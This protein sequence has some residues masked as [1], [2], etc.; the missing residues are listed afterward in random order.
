MKHDRF[1]TYITTL[2]SEHSPGSSISSVDP[3]SHNDMLKPRIGSKNH[4]IP[5]YTHRISLVSHKT[6]PTS[7]Q[8]PHVSPLNQ[9]ILDR[10]LH[11][12]LIGARREKVLVQLVGTGLGSLAEEGEEGGY[13][14]ISVTMSSH[15]DIV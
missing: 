12:H 7:P 1:L 2:N 6:H 3:I 4:L 5:I 15:D 8:S 14:Y 13:L 9:V 11:R 10:T